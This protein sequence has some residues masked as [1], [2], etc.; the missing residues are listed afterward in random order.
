[1][2][3]ILDHAISLSGSFDPDDDTR[4]V[5]GVLKP[6]KVLCSISRCTTELARPEPGAARAEFSPSKRPLRFST[7]R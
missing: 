1:M 2:N 5:L 4:A 7:P 3:W 6:T